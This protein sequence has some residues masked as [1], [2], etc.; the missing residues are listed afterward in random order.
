MCRERDEANDAPCGICHGAWGP[1]DYLS[2]DGPLSYE[3]DHILP[4]STHPELE[5]DMSNV[6][7]SHRMCN[8]SRRDGTRGGLGKPTR[9][10]NP[11]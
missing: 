2:D 6:R 11:A 1:I 3:P 5:L 7:A 8:R 4:F 10:W 9:N